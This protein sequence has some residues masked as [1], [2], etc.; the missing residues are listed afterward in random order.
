M[1]LDQERQRHTLLATVLTFTSLPVLL[2]GYVLGVAF[3]PALGY[4]WLTFLAVAAILAWLVLG[5]RRKP[6]SDSAPRI[7]RQHWPHHVIGWSRMLFIGLLSCWL[8]LMIWSVACP[9]GPDAPAKA[10]P[11]LIRV[12]TWNVHC[13]QDEGP[14]WQQFDWPARKHS[15]RAV[16]DQAQP[17]ILCVQEATPDQVAFLE[18]ILPK[19]HRVG[20]GRDGEA[21]GEHCAIYFSQ[22]R[23]EMLDGSTF[24]LEEPIDQ[25]RA[26][27]ALDVKRICTMVRLR[28]GLS[29]RT[30]RV[31]NTHLYLTEGRRLPAARL[32]LDHIAAGDTAD[33]VLL[34]ADFNAGPSAPS[35]RLFIE[36]GLA[37][38]AERAAKPVGQATFHNLYGIGFWSIDGILVDMHWRVLNHLILKAKPRNT[39]PSDH[40][41]LLAD[42]ELSRGP[43]H[44]DAP[45][46]DG[47]LRLQPPKPNATAQAKA[48]GY[49]SRRRALGARVGVVEDGLGLLFAKATPGIAVLGILVPKNGHREQ[50]CINRAG[51]ADGQRPDRDPGRHLYDGQERIE[52]LQRLG[53]HGHAEHRQ[54]RLGSDHPWKMR[55][56]AG[57]GDDYLEAAPFRGTDVL[58]QA[59]RRA[60]RRNHL[61]FMRHVE[62]FKRV[63]HVAHGFPV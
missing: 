18:K 34:T 8:G 46:R 48:C 14:P 23:F 5:L 1:A 2:V 63:C 28:D 4:S 53:L 36:A 3:L 9:S 16:L 27:S 37:D 49:P 30:I 38:S 22:Q 7:G 45:S 15:L 6:T 47:S 35:R 32:I 56:A 26:G 51:L 58:E 42:L 44:G 31:Y 17:D 41:A 62:L 61:H 52:S 25:P 21:G 29:R 12:M 11:E 24:W 19:F 57:A 60:M 59:I 55:G 20:I 43:V 40:F 54:H 33:A 39:Y 50:G 10:A 13:G